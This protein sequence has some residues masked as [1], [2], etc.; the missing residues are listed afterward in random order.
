MADFIMLEAETTIFKC[1]YFFLIFKINHRDIIF[2]KRII[3]QAGILSTDLSILAEAVNA[4]SNSVIITDHSKPDD[5]I[6]FCNP[7]FERLTGYTKDEVI[8]RNC[9]F[10]QGPDRSQ[11]ALSLV[12]EAISESKN[13]TVVLKNYRKDGVSFLNELSLSPI[14]D[15]DGKL[16]HLVGIQ[17][18]VPSRFDGSLYGQRSRIS[19][20]WRTPL[21]T[22]KGTLQILQRKGLSLNP[23]FLHKSLS[24]ALQAVE[25]LEQFANRLTR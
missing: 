17:R 3:M 14:F 1:Q 11:S 21:T 20:E 2:V 13:C 5:P 7:A 4:S 6:I 24:S 22:I 15:N 16:L 12:R 8:G 10:L 18:E 19:H 23:V 25:R 9:R